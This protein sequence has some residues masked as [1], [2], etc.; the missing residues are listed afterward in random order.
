MPH[1]IVSQHSRTIRDVSKILCYEI[2][3]DDINFKFLN[4]TDTLRK[5]MEVNLL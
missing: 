5:E 1:G 4:G 2:E 3:I